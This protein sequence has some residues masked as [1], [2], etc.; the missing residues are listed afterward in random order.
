MRVSCSQSINSIGALEKIQRHIRS[1]DGALHK[2]RDDWLR[3]I[4]IKTYLDG[5]ML[6]GS[7]YMR[8]PWG[9]SKYLCDPPTRSIAACFYPARTPAADRC[10]PPSNLAAH[11]FTAHSVGDGAVHTLLDVYEELANEGLPV[12][13]TRAC[14]THSNF[15]SKEAVEQ[16]ARLGIVIDLQPVW[17]HL[18]AA[19]VKAELATIVSATF[20]RSAAFLRRVLWQAEARDHMQKIGSL[21]SINPYP[22]LGMATAVTRR[23]ATLADGQLH[24]ERRYTRRNPAL[25]R[26]ITRRS[27]SRRAGRF[28]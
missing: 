11:E 15:M 10:A 12:R 13:E 14:I 2:E 17:L 19:L 24:P 26:S 9:I 3:I 16:A 23:L 7:A 27:C 5:G 1:V 8:A 20:S 4:G 25:L 18:D 6:T 21:R 28:P 22:F